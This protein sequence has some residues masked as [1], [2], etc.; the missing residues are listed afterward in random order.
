M[1]QA[2]FLIFILIHSIPL[3][4]AFTNFSLQM[5]GYSNPGGLKKIAQTCKTIESD[6]PIIRYANELDSIF[7]KSEIST[8]SCKDLIKEE[9][10]DAE[11]TKTNGRQKCQINRSI[12]CPLIKTDCALCSL[13]ND[14]ICIPNCAAVNIYCEIP[15]IRNC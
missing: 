4:D 9:L 13:T 2:G 10:N 1:F 6:S 11:L 8:T 3:N 15:L 14:P 5:H 12:F 7:T